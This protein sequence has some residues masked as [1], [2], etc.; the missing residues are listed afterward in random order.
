V[1]LVHGPVSWWCDGASFRV[2]V[3]NRPQHMKEETM[4]IHE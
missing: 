2:M 1:S 3:V 4:K